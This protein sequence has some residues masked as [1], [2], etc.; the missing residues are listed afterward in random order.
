MPSAQVDK[1]GS[2]MLRLLG[3]GLPWMLAS[4]TY[5][6]PARVDKGGIEVAVGI[7]LGTVCLFFGTLVW[8]KWRM[9]SS[10]GYFYIALYLLYVMWTLMIEYCVIPV[11]WKTKSEDNPFGKCDA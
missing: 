8:A 5:G 10:V 2:A 4:W 3:L 7:L 6:R 1:A 11:Y 9:R